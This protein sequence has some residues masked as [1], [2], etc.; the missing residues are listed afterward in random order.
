MRGSGLVQSCINGED[1]A[2]SEREITYKNGSV[3]TG[4]VTDGDEYYIRNGVGKM[5]WPDGTEYDGDWKD[6]EQNG[7]GKITWP[8]GRV[9]E[10]EWKDDNMHGRGKHTWPDGKV[11]EGVLKDNNMHGKGTMTWE[12]PDDNRL[13]YSGDWVDSYID[14]EGIT[15]W[16]DGKQ[17]F[18]RHPMTYDNFNRVRI[19]PN[20]MPLNTL[21]TF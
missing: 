17:Y 10:G 1:N 15:T 4:T 16:D 11:Y 2:Y 7:R 14:G 6:D 18:G 13:S 21:Q 9:Y 20:L 8:D 3:Y 12:V 5:T 19:A